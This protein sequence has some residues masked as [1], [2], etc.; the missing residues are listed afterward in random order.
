MRTLDPARLL[1]VALAAGEIAADREARRS[2]PGFR[3]WLVAFYE[4]HNPAR[5]GAVDAIL[6]KYA[7]REDD[8][9][10]RLER[11]YAPGAGRAPAAERRAPLSVLRPPPRNELSPERGAEPT[12]ITIRCLDTGDDLSMTPSALERTGGI[13]ADSRVARRFRRGLSLWNEAADAA[14]AAALVGDG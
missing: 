14:F 5:L 3:G 1:E 2:D 12:K 6:A 7:G 10:R 13:V 11:K 9:V 4:A 8:L